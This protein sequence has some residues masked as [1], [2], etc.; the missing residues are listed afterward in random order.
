MA[1]TLGPESPG[2][3]TTGC[4]EGETGFVSVGLLVGA[5]V[6]LVGV[7]G[8]DVVWAVVGGAAD[9]VVVGAPVDL[10]LGSAGAHPPVIRASAARATTTTCLPAARAAEV[11]STT[12]PS[13]LWLSPRSP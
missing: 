10:P 3:S 6:V 4:G 11:P 7:E 12:A 8:T 5:A 1:R 9:E 2:R 13:A